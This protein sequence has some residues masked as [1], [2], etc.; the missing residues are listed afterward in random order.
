M[1]RGHVQADSVRLRAVPYADFVLPHLTHDDCGPAWPAAEVSSDSPS[2]LSQEF[3]SAMSRLP[4]G[5]C[6][7]LT[8]VAGAE[9]VWGSTVGTAVSASL[10]P[11]MLVVLLGSHGRAA[12]LLRRR[13]AFT[14]SVL[15]HSQANISDALAGP[16]EELDRGDSRLVEQ[17]GHLVV[18]GAAAFVACTVD[19]F[20]TVGD[21]DLVIAVVTHAA[22]GAAGSALVRHRASYGCAGSN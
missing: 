20:I 15:A 10:D 2:A 11:P 12:Q 19:R 13:R 21:H 4:T 1:N 18:A 8:E 5:V 9:A 6:V 14:L 16:R 22:P 7:L 3:R 17:D